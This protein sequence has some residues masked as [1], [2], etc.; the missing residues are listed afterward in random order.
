MS[1]R[2]IG[3]FS[4]L[5]P[6]QP[7]WT[8]EKVP[9]QT[10]KVV[11][12][13]GGNRGIGKETARVL[14]LKGAKVYI[15]TRSAEKAQAAINELKQATGKDACFLK[16]DL[17]DLDSVK[18]AAEEFI[19]KESELH[20]LYNN[21]GVTYAPTDKVTA[22]GYDIQFGTN[23]LGYFY[24]T[25]LLLPV[26][27]ATAKASPGAVRVV[28][29]SSLVHYMGAREGIRWSTI[30]NGDR[31]VA[32]RKKLGMARLNGQSRLGNILFSNELARR[33]GGEG[34]VSIS[35]FPGAVN[36]DFSGYATSFVRRV[37]RMVGA[38]I[39]FIL[40][41]GDLDALTEEF[42]NRTDTTG[43]PSTTIATTTTTTT[44]TQDNLE[45]A[46]DR[47]SELANASLRA[48]T[49]LYAGTDPE[50]GKLNG[51]YLTAW[52]RVTLPHRKALN[53]ELGTKLWDWCEEQVKDIKAKE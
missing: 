53:Q 28:N 35:L 42:G 2:R 1:D 36:A 15:A 32:A 8:V 6:P 24:L 9:D 16:L 49:P 37:R 3:I 25:K 44:T 20:T 22:Q 10:G 13:T 11:I 19:G 31:A 14:L 5:V 43:R 34:I 40:S 46:Q 23:V 52:A 4:Q 29:M 47:L 30:N 50:A 26:L 27:T 45:N 17:A 12:I 51:K 38:C 33:Y 39:C 18:A 7:T 21:G 48:V 41:A